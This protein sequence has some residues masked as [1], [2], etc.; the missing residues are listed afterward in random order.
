MTDLADEL[1]DSMGRKVWESTNGSNLLTVTGLLQEGE[2]LIEKD[3]RKD[4]TIVL[5]C[6]PKRS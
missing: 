1:R 4:G 3:V 6:K 5:Q 2:Y